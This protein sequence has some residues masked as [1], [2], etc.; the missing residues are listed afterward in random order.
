MQQCLVH[1][2]KYNIFVNY[3]CFVIMKYIVRLIYFEKCKKNR[4]WNNFFAC[5]LRTQEIKLFVYKFFQLFVFPDVCV[6]GFEVLKLTFK[7]IHKL[8]TVVQTHAY[9]RLNER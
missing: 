2:V 3:V 6:V 5:L 7:T 1:S 8:L 9:C 4:I